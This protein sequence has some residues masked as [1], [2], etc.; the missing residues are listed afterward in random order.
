MPVVIN[1][2]EVTPAPPEP[3]PAPAKKESPPASPAPTDHEL[4]KMLER[5]AERL[6]RITAF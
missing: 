6:E 5:S 4:R 3:P 1:E 2:F